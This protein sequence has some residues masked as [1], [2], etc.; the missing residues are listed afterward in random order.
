GSGRFLL[1]TAKIMVDGV[2]ENET[3]SLLE[4]YLHPSGSEC[5]CAKGLG[6]SYFTPEELTQL[7]PLLNEAGL[8]AHMHAIGDRAVRD[9]LDAISHVSPELR[10]QRSNHLA[11]LQIVHP[12]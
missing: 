11:H 10:E 5:S 6:L 2:P 4:P 3:A 1:D 7:V 12:N 8:N 9:A